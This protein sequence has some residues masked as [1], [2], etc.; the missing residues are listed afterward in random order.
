MAGLVV[1]EEKIAIMCVP[2]L[3]Q[4]GPLYIG[5]WF[6]RDNGVVRMLHRI[7]CEH[8]QEKS[9]ASKS[10]HPISFKVSP[11]SVGPHNAVLIRIG[12][13]TFEHLSKGQAWHVERDST[14]SFT[15]SPTSPDSQRSHTVVLGAYHWVNTINPA[16]TL[17]SPDQIVFYQERGM[18]IY[19]F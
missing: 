14:T 17:N 16:N 2:I 5:R 18:Y 12:T 19:Y 3:F 13:S 11:T 7:V 15:R 6:S 8:Y 10:I 1:Q 4:E 9:L